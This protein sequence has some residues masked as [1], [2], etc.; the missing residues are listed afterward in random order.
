VKDLLV[1]ISHHAS[2]DR[3]QYLLRVLK[4]F[5]DHY[6]TS[7]DIII[8]TN[9]AV[10][11]VT[12]ENVTTVHHA[13]LSHPFHLAWQH[14]KHMKERIEDYHWLMYIEDDIYLPYENFVYYQQRFEQRWP[15]YIPSF[16]RV[17]KFNGEEFVVDVTKRQQRPASQFC[18]LS[19]PY[20]G[21]WIM[22][23]RALKET[24]T[25]DLVRLS[26]SRE[27]AASYP[28]ED[29]RKVPFVN[30]EDG[31]ISRKCFAYHLP[32]NYSSCPSSPHGKIKVS[33]IFQ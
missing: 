8:D 30:L 13:S 23:Q 19:Q 28:M 7:H 32:N 6:K 26:D 33:E 15:G 2:P 1:C 11:S 3:L 25:P 14:R 16:I 20:H 9:V 29:L 21:F 4:S 22:P 31:Q 18:T 12:G 27:A 24:M 10:L 5:S 17:E